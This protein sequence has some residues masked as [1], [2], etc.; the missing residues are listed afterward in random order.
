M[1]AKDHFGNI[2]KNT[3]EMF[4]SC[5]SE[6]MVEG[7]SCLRK[8]LPLS[9]GTFSRE[10]L[11]G[12]LSGLFDG[13][14]SLS[15]SH[16]KK[17]PQPVANFATSSR[18]LVNSVE[19]LCKLLNIRTSTSSSEPRE[20][21][22]QTH[23]S[24]LVSLSI[25]DLAQYADELTVLGEKKR[26]V[27][28]LLKTQERRDIVDIIPVPTFVMNIITTS[29]GPM[30]GHEL[31]KSLGTVKSNRKASYYMSRDMANIIFPILVDANIRNLER[32]KEVIDAT[33]VHWDLVVSVTENQPE[34]VYDLVVPSTKVFAV[35]G[36]LI[37]W[38]TMAV[39]LPLTEQA[40]QEALDKMLPSSNLFSATN[41]GI[42]H[43]PDQ[44][45][46]I[47]INNLSHWGEKKEVTFNSLADLKKN[48]DIKVHDVVK[49]KIGNEYKE[50]TKG[51]ALLAEN[52]PL[53]MDHSKLLHDPSLELKKGNIHKMLETFARKD[54]KGY[55][56][57][58]DDWR[59]KGNERAHEMGF[60]FSLSDLNPLKAK[61]SAI[62]APYHDE[63]A[64]VNK[65]SL[66]QE[67]KDAKIVALYNKATEELDE[68]LSK[69]YK[70][71]GNNMFK[72][73]DT[74]ARGS[75]AQFRQTVIAPMLLVD[76]NNKVITTPV[77]NSYSEGLNVSQYWT[78]LHGARKGTLQRAQGTSVPGALAKEL[79]NL[80]IATPI[81]KHD[82]GDEHGL[83]MKLIDKKGNNE[84][85][86]TDRFL[87]KDEHGFH[88]GT[89]I[90]PEV[91]G[92]LK[93]NNVTSVTVRSPLTCKVPQGICSTCF[94]LNENGHKHEIG[95]NIGVLASQALSE[96]AVQLAMDCSADGNLVSVKI[97]GVITT[98][99]FEQLWEHIGGFTSEDDGIET[100]MPIN[101]E[102]WDH[103]KWVEVR[104]FQ[105]HKVDEPMVL[106]RTSSGRSFIV[107]ATHPSWAV[108][109]TTETENKV[110]AAKDLL[111]KWVP[112]SNQQVDTFTFNRY[113]P[114]TLI[115]LAIK[116]DIE[117][118]VSREAALIKFN[119]EQLLVKEQV[120][121]SLT[122]A[123][124]SYTEQDNDI[125]LTDP[126]IT[127]ELAL[128]FT[129]DGKL[130][131]PMGFLGAPLQWKT[132]LLESLVDFPVDS[133]SVIEGLNW[134][135]ASQLQE[136]ARNM[137][138]S[139]SLTSTAEN[140]FSLYIDSC[141]VKTDIGYDKV[142]SIEPV[143]YDGWTYDF[144]TATK[145][146]TTNGITTHN[147]FHSGGVAQSRGGGSSSKLER[148]SQLLN[149]P[150]GLPYSATLAK[151]NGVIHSVEKDT[152]GGHKVYIQN[153][154]GV[155]E[156]YVPSTLDLI[157]DKGHEV[158][159]GE[160]IS[161]GPVNPHQLLQ[162]KDMGAVRKYLTTEMG[163]MYKDVGGVRRRNVEVVVKNLTNLTEVVSSGSSDH[164]PGDILS[165][166][167]VDAHNR[168]VPTENRI[169][170][171]PILRGIKET[172]LLKDEDYL[173][174]M[175]FQRIQ[176]T[177]IEGVGKGWKTTTKDTLSPLPA[178]A[179]GTIDVQK[180]KN[181]PKY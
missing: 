73:V 12:V 113:V 128:H 40:R 72:M 124:I 134:A 9:L 21:R 78:S 135:L 122:E 13:D 168:T 102:V 54:P 145:S 15:V 143:L 175:N 65:S 132:E 174:K 108:E 33:N 57:L 44:E 92:K 6:E 18:F 117:L 49:V 129:N 156:H 90:T 141:P 150:K 107:K 96:P 8:Q 59:K 37:V 79:I 131:L 26:E 4:K 28:H 148:L 47:G 176:N 164:L 104:T 31:F 142:T 76:A 147:S 160:A 136:L 180:D 16:G 38:D 144:S 169:L 67:N 149:L 138:M 155:H 52:A 77:L 163:D 88:K 161:N 115:G 83:E 87:A 86:V 27:L 119:T 139:S 133:Y 151:H 166:A 25:N 116:K 118:Q 66:S 35:N 89:L 154:T 1:S 158:K 55:P 17:K 105:R 19:L 125:V 85:D 103:N 68:K 101:L 3:L 7:R 112:V 173:S 20:G 181:N 45:A 2:N 93:A 34:T 153:N 110:F 56:T 23:T 46:I 50:T 91:F 80:N 130:Q 177:V 81:T 11:V 30:K 14:G 152:A 137:Y 60:S 179:A 84:I 172:A 69:D 63:V 42:M 114:V 41:Y 51:R 127:R 178:W 170:H 157:V 48:K 53:E 61:R 120:V 123:K 75:L 70:A 24:Y 98:L 99:T 146:Y 167:I 36:G 10:A 58:V 162:L 165:T 126:L 29:S 5:Y 171:K 39:H 140:L 32:W 109:D 82:C 159:R 106:V 111:N 43:A 97:N 64:K 62:L 100:K 121:D 95:T 94:G 74:K 71:M 22:L